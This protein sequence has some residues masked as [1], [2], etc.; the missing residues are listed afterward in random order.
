MEKELKIEVN[1]MELAEKQSQWMTDEC[2]TMRFKKKKT[3][4]F[5]LKN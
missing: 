5:P 2:W 1:E 3:F 4:G